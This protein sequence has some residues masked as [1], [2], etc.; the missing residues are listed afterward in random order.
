MRNV[1]SVTMPTELEKR[2][3]RAEKLGQQ[4][5]NAVEIY[6]QLEESRKNVL[7]DLQNALDD[8]YKS[9][10]KLEREARGSNE[11]KQFVKNLV[12]AKAAML[13]LKVTYEAA[14][15]YYEAARTAEASRRVETM[16]LRDKP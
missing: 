5:V 10:S 7:A 15:A 6:D 2:I 1:Q 3:V 11:W 9:E 8:G 14:V 13:R 12:T 4:W 16:I